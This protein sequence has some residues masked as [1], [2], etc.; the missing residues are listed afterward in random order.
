MPTDDG[1]MTSACEADLVEHGTMALQKVGPA[2]GH[3]GA[4]RW[5]TAGVVV[6][7]IQHVEEVRLPRAPRRAPHLSTCA[8]CAS[9]PG[10]WGISGRT[11]L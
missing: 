1:V 9:L 5:P 11:W 3:F 10:R 7:S 6:T 4:L 2:A 8:S